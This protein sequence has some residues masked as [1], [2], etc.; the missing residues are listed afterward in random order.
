MKTEVYLD[1]ALKGFEKFKKEAV[2]IAKSEN[3]GDYVNEATYKDMLIQDPSIEFNTATGSLF[4][5]GSMYKEGVDMGY[6]SFDTE[7]SL[8]LAVDIVNYYM[9]KLGKLKTVLEATK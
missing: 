5:N 6:I 4:L 3:G 8:D 1:M 9:K 7:V 2:E